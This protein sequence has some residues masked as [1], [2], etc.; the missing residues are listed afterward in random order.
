MERSS[1]VLGAEHPDTLTSMNNLTWTWKSQ[2]RD[3]DAFGLM[4]ECYL[5]RKQKLGADHPN[6][7]SSLKAMKEWERASSK[8]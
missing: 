7:I 3:I 5:L 4:S 8:V 2:G 6:T 1:R